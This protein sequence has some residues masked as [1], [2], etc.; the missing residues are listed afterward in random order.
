[1]IRSIFVVTMAVIITASLSAAVVIFSLFPSSGTI[2]RRIARFWAKIILCFS[3]IKVEVIGRENVTTERPQ[4]FMANHQGYFDIPIFLAHIPVDFLW[5][6]KKEL[7]H[8]PVFG[9]AMRQAG[10]IEIDRQDREKAVKGME[11][12]GEEISKGL[13]IATFPEGTISMEG[14]ILPFKQGMFHI[15]IQTGVSIV[16]ITIIGSDKIMPKGSLKVGRGEIIMVIDK[17]VEA[18]DY[19]IESRAALIEKVR[20]IIVANHEKYQK[21]TAALPGRVSP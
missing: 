5:T 1:M 10:Y 20:E 21:G 18:G 8:V 6:A 15:A 4:I 13:S 9:R 2:S 17:P 12:A 7:F 11:E 16:P 19:T 3:Q 14:K